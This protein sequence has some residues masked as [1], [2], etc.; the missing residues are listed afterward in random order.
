M[1]KDHRVFKPSRHKNRGRIFIFILKII[2][3]TLILQAIIPHFLISSYQ[4][5]SISMEPAVTT[6]DRILVS[7]LNYGFFFPFSDKRI[8]GFQKPVRGELVLINPPFEKKTRFPLSFLNGF[9]KL[10]TLNIVNIDNSVPTPHIERIIGI[11][12][13]T[14]KVI[15]HI[16]YIKTSNSDRFISESELIRK[17]YTINI[18]STL[19]RDEWENEYLI[20]GNLNEIILNK[21]EY[22]VL[23]DNRT[24]SN[25]SRSWGKVGYSNILSKI[26]L[27]YF[28]FKKIGIPK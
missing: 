26:F 5:K 24:A 23:G 27:R 28:P 6:G 2:I 21:D 25:D 17:K 16:A 14:V 1:I 7:P 3:V 11:P 10:I 19:N 18:D 4:V 20:S 15:N 12:G 9:I 22:F 13:D 8:D